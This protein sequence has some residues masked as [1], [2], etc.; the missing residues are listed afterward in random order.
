MVLTLEAIVDSEE[1]IRIAI[2]QLREKKQPLVEKVEDQEVIDKIEDQEFIDTISP[3]IE[4]QFDTESYE[5]SSH[6]INIGYDGKSTRSYYELLTAA[7][8]DEKGTSASLTA[9]YSEHEHETLQEGQVV[10]DKAHEAKNNNKFFIEVFID[11]NVKDARD[12]I[13]L[14]SPALWQVMYDGKLTFN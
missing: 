4:Q 3:V 6:S 8:V 2:E 9:V 13:K 5:R 10:A 7:E 12:S 11:S 14:F 1:E